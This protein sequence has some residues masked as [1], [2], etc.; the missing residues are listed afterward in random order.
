MKLIMTAGE[1]TGDRARWLKAR[2]GDDTTGAC[3]GGSLIADILA[4]DGA[5]GRPYKAWM[6]LTGRL[7]D[8]GVTDQMR[9]GNFCEPFSRQLLTEKFWDQ[10]FTPGG[11]YAHDAAPWWRVT[12]DL[13]AHPAAACPGTGSVIGQCLTGPAVTVQQKNTLFDDWGRTGVPASYRAQ[14]LWEAG[15]LLERPR[16]RRRWCP[17][18]SVAGAVRPQQSRRG[19]F[20]DPA[21][22]P[23][24]AG[25]HDHDRGRGVDAGPGTPGRSPTG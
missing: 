23:G 3:I 18:R 22:R 1:V 10:H 4:L 11:L 12:F 19:H 9:F 25:H 14:A 6:T 7:A 5:H 24:D 17:H 21:G 15:V 8:E 16:P 20:R 2:Q 13:L